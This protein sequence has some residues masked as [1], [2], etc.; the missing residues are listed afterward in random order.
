MLFS[1]ETFIFTHTK[2]QAVPTEGES[3]QG[4]QTDTENGENSDAETLF[5]LRSLGELL[6]D[7]VEAGQLVTKKNWWSKKFK[8]PP[9]DPKDFGIEDTTGSFMSWNKVDF[10]N[11]Q[12]INERN[13]LNSK[14]P[15]ILHKQKKIE[16]F[17]KAERVRIANQDK[18]LDEIDT[19][20]AKLENEEQKNIKKPYLT[21]QKKTQTKDDMWKWEENRT[22]LQKPVTYH[23]SLTDSLDK[24][25]EDIEEQMDDRT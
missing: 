24:L 6:R 9:Q 15:H 14:L 10:K 11:N 22:K 8:S 21:K 17:D 7:S 25:L 23:D 12:E 20:L 13:R 19:L 18:A 3:E 2:E 4:V 1:V 5:Q 16:E